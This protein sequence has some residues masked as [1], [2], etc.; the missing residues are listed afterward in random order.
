MSALVV[1]PQGKFQKLDFSNGTSVFSEQANP[2]LVF[3]ALNDLYYPGI[4]VIG[5]GKPE[6]KIFAGYRVIREVQ[7]ESIYSKGTSRE[8][9]AYQEARARSAEACHA[10]LAD[11]R[12]NINL[13]RQGEEPKADNS[14]PVLR[15][16][17]IR[18]ARAVPPIPEIPLS[19]ESRV[20]PPGSLL[21][22]QS[23]VDQK[24]GLQDGYYF[25]DQ[26]FSLTPEEQELENLQRSTGIVLPTGQSVQGADHFS[27]GHDMGY[28]GWMMK[29]WPVAS[30][31]VHQK[32]IDYVRSLQPPRQ[33][34]LQ[35]R[36]YTWFSRLMNRDFI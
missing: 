24:A 17:F 22:C 1:R 27:T 15:E 19:F 36:P 14:D 6:Y 4:K 11:L 32:D 5:P 23:S 9:E 2:T 30:M 18:A 16:A 26:W 3:A 28:S 20:L 29:R 25:S 31:E 13:I 35:T 33:E 21:L 8:L 12:E 10:A 7:T 34:K